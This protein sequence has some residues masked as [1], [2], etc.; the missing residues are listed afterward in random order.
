VGKGTLKFKI[1]SPPKA[2]YAH[3]WSFCCSIGMKPLEFPDGLYT[4]VYEKLLKS[5]I[6]ERIF[7]PLAII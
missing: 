3:A 7:F 2:S 1:T 5:G 6:F 4:E